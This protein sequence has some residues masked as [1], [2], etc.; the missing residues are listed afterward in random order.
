MERKLGRSAGIEILALVTAGELIHGVMLLI[1]TI[2]QSFNPLKIPRPVLSHRDNID[3][4]KEARHY[5][6]LCYLLM[7]NGCNNLF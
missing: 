7:P 5:M 4:L 3:Q 2:E 1:Y 6:Q